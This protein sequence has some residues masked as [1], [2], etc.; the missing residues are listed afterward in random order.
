MVRIIANDKKAEVI[1]LFALSVPTEIIF[2][3]ATDLAL[4]KQTRI[5]AEAAYG[6]GQYITTVDSNV[7][8][9]AFGIQTFTG[10]YEEFE[11]YFWKL[12]YLDSKSNPFLQT[13]FD[14]KGINDSNGVNITLNDFRSS[15]KTT[16]LVMQEMQ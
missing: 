6:V 15:F 12:S 5:L 4:H 1:I 8:S 7:I 2:Q 10:T 16:K 3:H 9:G 14:T 13:F 11:E